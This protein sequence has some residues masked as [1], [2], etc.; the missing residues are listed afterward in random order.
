MFSVC[1]LSFLVVFAY[2]PKHECLRMKQSSLQAP[3]FFSFAA[4]SKIACHPFVLFLWSPSSFCTC[5]YFPPIFLQFLNASE[6][7]LLAFLFLGGVLPCC[8][9]AIFIPP[10]H[11]TR[12]AHKIDVAKGT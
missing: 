2:V 1:F 10:D 7:F 3:L 9:P 12:P 8:S 11:S 6:S 4:R 5:W